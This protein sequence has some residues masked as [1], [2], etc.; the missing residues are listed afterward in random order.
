METG[1]SKWQ[2][3]REQWAPLKYG[4]YPFRYQIRALLRGIILNASEELVVFLYQ[5]RTSLPFSFV[6]IPCLAFGYWGSIYLDIH[7]F[8][9]IVAQTM[10]A[11]L[12]VTVTIIVFVAAIMNERLSARK[13]ESKELFDEIRLYREDIDNAI[14]NYLKVYQP[15]DQWQLS[16][17]IQLFILSNIK[18]QEDYPRLK[19]LIDEHKRLFPNNYQQ[20]D[21]SH[22][23]LYV[24]R[25]FDYYDNVC[26]SGIDVLTRLP[27]SVVGRQ[28]LE[29]F[30][31]LD[32]R[33]DTKFDVIN[34][35]KL[36]E[37]FGR[38]LIRVIGYPLFTLILLLIISS[39]NEPHWNLFSSIDFHTRQWFKGVVLSISLGSLLLLTRYLML[40]IQFL[41]FDLSENHVPGP[42]VFDPEDPQEIAKG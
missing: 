17:L 32:Y 15:L 14:K 42:S 24:E 19:A 9:N 39:A 38:R 35:Y 36:S 40:I 26:K 11:L 13:L 34:T 22:I 1:K 10:A 33:L 6:L 21:F 2:L 20:W 18:G 23:R 8:S 25:T 41:R 3:I 28:Q 37:L 16:S 31:A 5:L 7:K 12:G 4:T 29:K 30:Q 27:E